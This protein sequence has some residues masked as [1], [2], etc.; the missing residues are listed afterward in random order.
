MFWKRETRNEKRDGD[1]RMSMGTTGYR[2]SNIHHFPTIG[3]DDEF[4]VIL[5]EPGKSR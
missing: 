3:R 5:S 1:L 4:N 2:D